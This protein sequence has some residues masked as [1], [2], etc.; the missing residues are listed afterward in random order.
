M[1]IA[2]KEKIEI[3]Y[4]KNHIYENPEN[5]TPNNVVYKLSE[6]KVFLDKIDKIHPGSFLNANNILEIG[7]GQGW[8]T[9]IIKSKFPG[10]NVIASDISKYALASLN[11]WERLFGVKLD[12]AI[13]CKGYDLP[14]PDKSID[15]VFTFQSFHHFGKY[16]KTLG[17][18]YR[19][20]KDGGVCLLLHEPSCSGA[21]YKLAFKRV[22]AKRPQVPED[23]IKYKEIERMAKEAGFKEARS[24]F[25]PDITN[26]RP[27]PTIYYSILG[28][29][30]FLQKI[31][32][33]TADIY[34]K[35]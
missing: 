24:F 18:I 23:V 19:V 17:E 20:L 30:K 26:R 12:R 15:L 5:F 31:L 35:K 32:P 29:L 11:H 28:K 6:A 2:E 14:L 4:W 25:A 1:E 22:N 33:C 7:A 10:K 3:E 8:A 27:L 21:L 16:E 9:C 34:M 13:A